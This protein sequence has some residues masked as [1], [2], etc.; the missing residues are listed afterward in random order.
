MLEATPVVPLGGNLTIGIAL[1]SYDGMLAV[2]LHA[3][4]DAAPDLPVLADALTSEFAAL[5]ALVLPGAG[6][7]HAGEHGG[8]AAGS[9]RAGGAGSSAS[10]VGHDQ[11]GADA[12]RYGPGP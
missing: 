2:G 5:R 11:S 9:E 7:V 12:V 8:E 6:T 1:L 10:H 3:D 4:A